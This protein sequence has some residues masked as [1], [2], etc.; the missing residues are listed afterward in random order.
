M[1]EHNRFNKVSYKCKP[2][3]KRKS[4][5]FNTPIRLKRTELFFNIKYKTRGMEHHTE[6]SYYY[7]EDRFKGRKYIFIHGCGILEMRTDTYVKKFDDDPILGWH[8]R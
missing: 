5:P 8:N 4:N 1:F 3:F 2:W 6:D 7:F